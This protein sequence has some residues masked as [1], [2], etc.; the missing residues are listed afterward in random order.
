MARCHECRVTQNFSKERCNETAKC[1]VRDNDNPRDSA[2]GGSLKSLCAE[3]LLMDV[4]VLNYSNLD[5]RNEP[6]HCQV[7]CILNLF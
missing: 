3:T 2:I 5:Y 4:G 6:S 1:F 7:T